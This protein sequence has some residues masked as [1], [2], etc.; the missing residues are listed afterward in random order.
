MNEKFLTEKQK[1]VMFKKQR[2]IELRQEGFKHREIKDKLNSELKALGHKEV[3]LSYVLK[4][5]NQYKEQI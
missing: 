4:Y 5:W 3:S 2:I 1:L